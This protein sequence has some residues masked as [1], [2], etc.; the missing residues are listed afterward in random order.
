MYVY[1]YVCI[2]EHMCFVVL[3]I[4][5]P[6]NM[7]S[8]ICQRVYKYVNMTLYKSEN[9]YVCVCVLQKE[10]RIYKKKKECRIQNEDVFEVYGNQ[11]VYP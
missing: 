4:G 1:M 8:I 7:Y 2:H 6:Y 11:A 3:F 9:V 5:I 10:C